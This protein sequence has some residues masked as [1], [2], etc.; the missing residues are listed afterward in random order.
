MFKSKYFLAGFFPFLNHM[1]LTVAELIIRYGFDTP[2][3]KGFM[4]S[5]FGRILDDPELLEYSKS[6][7]KG[8]FKESFRSKFMY[9]RDLFGF[10]FCYEKVKN[11][12]HNYPLD[13]LNYS[14]AKETFNAILKSCSDFDDAGRLQVTCTESSSSWNMHIFSILCKAKGDFHPDVYSDFGKLLTTSS[15]VES[16][17][18]PQAMQD[19]ANQIVKDVGSKV[20]SSMELQGEKFS[21]PLLC[22][23]KF[24]QFLKKHGHRCL[25]ELDVRSITWGMDPKLLVKL[26]QNLV[27]ANKGEAKEEDCS[28]NRIISQ[29]RVPLTFMSKCLLR[30]VVPQCHRA[31][32]G[33][34]AGKIFSR[35]S[36]CGSFLVPAGG[37]WKFKEQVS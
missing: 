18:I 8:E 23:H 3:S 28:T 2:R 7:I 5:I 25:K 32:R 14:T 11:K 21:K 15:T 9:Y 19:V 6:K 29:L 37:I 24:Q 12:I 34:E 20:F 13:F 27:S 1:M 31:V 33:R 10:D 22:G 4:I 17:T 36:I 16:A 26:L 35:G 30:I